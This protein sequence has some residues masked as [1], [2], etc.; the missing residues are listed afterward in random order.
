MYVEAQRHVKEKKDFS[1]FFCLSSS[2]SH[3]TVVRTFCMR[4]YMA[5]IDASPNAVD[6]RLGVLCGCGARFCGIKCL[7]AAAQEH[8]AVCENIQKALQAL[9]KSQ[10][11]ATEKTNQV[12]LEWGGHVQINLLRADM[13]VAAS[14]TVNAFLYAANSVRNAEAFELAQKLAQRALSLS[15]KGSLDEVRALNMLGNVASTLSK[16]DAAVTYYEAALKIRKSLQ[17]IGRASW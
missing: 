5:L 8:K 15:A 16:Y 7:V 13:V 1:H 10:F 17:E 9:A 6:C 3:N 4:C 11:R 2:S 12:A 14:D